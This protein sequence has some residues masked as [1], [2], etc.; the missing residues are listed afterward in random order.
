[1]DYQCQY[2]GCDIGGKWDL[3]VVFLRIAGESTIVSKKATIIYLLKKK[4][5]FIK[6]DS[7]FPMF[8]NGQGRSLEEMPLLTTPAVGPP[9]TTSR[10]DL[11]GSIRLWV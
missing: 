10:A 6:G 8:A 3:S 1:M 2:Q 11:S 4:Y 5:N 9:R 7:G